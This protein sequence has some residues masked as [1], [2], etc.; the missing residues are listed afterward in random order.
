MQAQKGGMTTTQRTPQEIAEKI[1]KCS[2]QRKDP[3]IRAIA[4]I[5]E[6]E[7][8]E[9]REQRRELV[10]ALNF[11]LKHRTL[12][13]SEQCCDTDHSSPYCPYGTA[14][15]ALAKEGEL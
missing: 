3:A 4:A 11:I 12:C 7:R 9:A 1:F 10:E 5:I 2:L 15:T 6:R 14:R 13:H 8:T